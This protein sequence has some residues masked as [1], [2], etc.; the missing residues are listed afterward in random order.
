MAAVL[1]P[2]SVTPV[3]GWVPSFSRVTTM[4][5]VELTAR[6]LSAVSERSAHWNGTVVTPGCQAGRQP[7]TSAIRCSQVPSAFA[8]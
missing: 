6:G 8:A 1:L 4:S 7:G 5:P 2:A 3:S